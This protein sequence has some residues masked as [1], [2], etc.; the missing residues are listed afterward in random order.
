M[1][2]LMDSTVSDGNNKLLLVAVE[3]KMMDVET[4]TA[5]VT[6]PKDML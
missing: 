5:Y 3:T 2:R 1:F 4:K 6:F